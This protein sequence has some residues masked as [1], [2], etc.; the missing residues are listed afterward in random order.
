MTGHLDS[1]GWPG[2]SVL[3]VCAHPDDESFG[4]GAVLAD[5]ANRGASV[6][7]LCFTQGE[8]STLSGQSRLLGEVR[9]HE[10]RAAACVLGL[11]ST[12]LLDYPD[13]DLVRIPLDELAKHVASLADQ[14]GAQALL[15]FDVGGV[16]GHPDHHRATE[17]ALRAAEHMD[18]PVMGWAVPDDVASELNTEL[19]THFL[20]RH[21]SETSVILDVDRTQQMRAIACHVSQSRDNPVLWRRLDLQGRREYLNWLRRPDR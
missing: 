11:E 9:N 18:L 13:G 16:T 17:A 15:A 5:A 20:G 8:A 14:I 10:L 4:L 21:A 19:G 2:P 12:V 1:E 3:A 7:L 6:G